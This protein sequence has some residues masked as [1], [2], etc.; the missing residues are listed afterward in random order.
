MKFWQAQTGY[1]PG[2][3]IREPRPGRPAVMIPQRRHPPGEPG[4]N[5]G[6]KVPEMGPGHL[7]RTANPDQR[8]IPDLRVI[9]LRYST[10]VKCT[11]YTH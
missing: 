3:S 9:G 7:T 4:H 11:M 2:P 10:V 5:V 8:K 1:C 6:P